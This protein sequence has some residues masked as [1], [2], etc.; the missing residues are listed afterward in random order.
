MRASEELVRAVLGDEATDAVV[1]RIVEHAGGNA[2]MLEELIRTASQPVTG[3]LP[4]S[5]VAIGRA[6]LE[7]IE[8]EARRI[9]KAASVFGTSFWPDAVHML[10]GSDGAK[11]LDKSL[12][13]LEAR[14]FIGRDPSRACHPQYSFRTLVEA[15][16]LLTD[17]DRA[18]AHHRRWRTR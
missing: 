4:R 6:R 16:A 15:H 12:A 14:E 9:L 17:D 5:A 13:S 8:P 18:V 2:F 7:R 1:A 10:V 3:G 11:F